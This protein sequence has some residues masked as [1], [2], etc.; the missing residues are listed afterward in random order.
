[1]K[2]YKKILLGLSFLFIASCGD[3]LETASPGINNP[4]ELEEDFAP[5]FFDGEEDLTEED[6]LGGENHGDLEDYEETLIEKPISSQEAFRFSQTLWDECNEA[7]TGNYLS[8]GCA[9]RRHISVILKSFLAD[10]IYKC[11]DQALAAQGGGISDEIHI[12]HAGIAG[13]RRHSPRSL[14]AEN[15]AVDIK[16]IKVRLTN[17][18][19]RQFTYAK[20]GNRPFYTALR[21]CWGKTVSQFNECPLYRGTPL[22]T[23]SIGWENRNHGRHMHMSVPY[24]YNNRHGSYYWVR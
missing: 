3:S 17:G 21:N 1:M 18:L 23:G 8:Y 11:V 14:H 2:E 12:T 15:R 6:T 19:S 9:R 24:C 13:D 4:A 10:H 20:I 7:V 5:G 16:V 22:Y